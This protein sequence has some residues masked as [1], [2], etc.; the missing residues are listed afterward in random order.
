MDRDAKSAIRYALL[1]ND[2]NYVG[3]HSFT[4]AN[5]LSQ[6]AGSSVE[7]WAHNSNELGALHVRNV[8]ELSLAGIKRRLGENDQS[9][10]FKI[11]WL[12]LVWHANVSYWRSVR[13]ASEGS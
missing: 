8:F 3:G 10:K 11:R 2:L 9:W 5:A 4:M 1:D 13:A 7:I 6:V 12:A